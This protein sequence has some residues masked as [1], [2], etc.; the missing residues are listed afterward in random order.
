MDSDLERVKKLL[1]GKE[2]AELLALKKELETA[3][4]LTDTVANVLA[5]ALEA[6]TRQD[7]RISNVLAPTIDQA[8]AGSIDQDPKK[9]AESLYPI[10][11]PAIRKSIAETLQQ[12]LENFNQLLEQSLSPKSLRWR[13]DAWR[14]GR[15]YSELVLLNT[16]EYE[17]QQVFLIHTET[18][19]LISHVYSELTAHNDPDMV[20]SMLSA[21][22]DF[23]ADSFS[24]GDDD[25]LDALRLGELSIVV[26]SGPNAILAA[27]VR[28]TIPEHLRAKMQQ[29]SETLH[30]I[31]R[32]QLTNFDGDTAEFADVEDDLRGILES[33]QRQDEEEER[34][35]PWLAIVAIVVG[36]S[37]SGY[38]SYEQQKAAAALQAR[39]DQLDAVPG[40]VVL[41]GEARD[42]A[43]NV[44]LPILLD[45]L[46]EGY[47]PMLTDPLGP[48]ISLQP[49]PYVS[50][51]DEL[52][53][54][55]ALTLLKPESETSVTVVDGVVTLDGRAAL[56]WYRDASSLWETVPGAAGYADDGLELY[57]P[58]ANRMLQ[59]GRQIE[60][61]TVA[62]EKEVAEIEE[63]T[64]GI[65]QLARQL[66][67]MNKL[68]ES[69][70]RRRFNFMIVGY[71]DDSG[72]V[73]Y[74]RGMGTR[75]AEQ[76]RD[77]LV[78]EGVAAGELE[79]MN[80][81]DYMEGETPEAKREV[82]IFL[83]R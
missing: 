81:F 16:L 50:A 9:L 25:S 6:R 48:S 38:F 7:D 11:G 72:S 51:E 66:K 47:E 43:G 52:I 63:I 42:E 64:P 10:M 24:I 77:M 17:V 83:V 2:Y 69:E 27:V 54:K 18:S 29:T 49:S 3:E 78:A 70:G 19:L 31:K 76:L 67:E 58:V 71:T 46:A 62:F 21:V 40:I 53:L 57:D 55:R 8:I 14:T 41:P 60:S 37:I 44:L 34:K 5:E 39:V 65:R 1:L 36:L 68:A 13:F 56:Q 4:A 12:M 20:S 32:Q 61:F 35:I 82:R 26:H 15:S 30:R 73:R 75:R 80:S 79:V 59:L 23:V 74:N 33:K 22:R 45:P 28:G